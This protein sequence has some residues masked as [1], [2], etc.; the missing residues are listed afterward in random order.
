MPYKTPEG[1][2]V[3][4][5]KF[6]NLMKNFDGGSRLPTSDTMPSRNIQRI[7]KIALYRKNILL[8]EHKSAK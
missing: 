7:L 3:P 8:T 4:H 6:D 5:E 2:R 1:N